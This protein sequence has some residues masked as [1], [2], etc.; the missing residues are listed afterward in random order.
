MADKKNGAQGAGSAT[1][2]ETGR[3]RKKIT[4]VEAVGRA[5]AALGEDASRGDLQ[6]YVRQ[7]FGVKIGLDHISNCK[8]ELAKRAA[9]AP[10]SAGP[11]AAAVVQPAA[12]PAASRKPTAPE[13]RAA[14]PT[15]AP[16]TRT[17]GGTGSSGAIILLEDVLTAK[18]LINRVGAG[19]LKTLIDGLA[20]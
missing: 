18:L 11:K 20:Q 15:R 12:A 4:K 16:Q 7:K 14:Q 2:T 9:K 1:A 3:K 13:S 8:G 17:A 5:M 19:P 6:G 10:P